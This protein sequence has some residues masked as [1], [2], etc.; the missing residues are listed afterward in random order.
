V[1]YQTAQRDSM[2]IDWD[3]PI[4]MDDGNVLR[5]D[6]FR[7]AQDGQHPLLLTYGPYAKGLHFE[8]GYP[9]A[10][11]MMCAD[12]PDV[13]A[14][15]TNQYQ[16]WEV[17]DPEKWVPEGYVCVRVD[18]RGAG[19]SPGV[20]DCFSPR[21]VQDLY[22]CIEWAG[23]QSWSSGQVALLG[24]SY[25]AVMQ[26]RVAALQPPHLAALVAWEGL[27]DWYRDGGYHGG[28]RS[29]FVSGWYPN[30]VATVQHG[31]GDR[32]KRSRITGL[33][34]A[35]DETLSDEELAANKANFDKAI[36]AHPFDGQFYDERRADLSK[37][38]VPILSAGNWGGHGLHLRGNVEAFLGAASEHKW[39]ELHGVE[40]WVHFYTDYGREL[41]LEFL[42]HF[43][44]GID[45]GWDR[46]PQVLMNVRHPDETFVFR[47]ETAWP[48][49]RT[50]WTE[51]HLDATDMSLR[52]DPPEAAGQV[53]YAPMSGGATFR[54]LI[55]EP[56]E[57]TGPAAATL[58]IA[59]QTED[60]DLFLIL[61]VF[62]PAGVEVAYAGAVQS[63][64]PVAHGWLRASHRQLD[65]E[66]SLRWRPWHPHREREPL[67]PGRTYEVQVEIWPTSIVIPAGYTLALAIQ[68]HDYQP[69]SDVPDI[70]LQWV[71]MR[72][73]GPF[74]HDDPNDRPPEVFG[75]EVTL[76]T[77]GGRSS[78]VLLPVIPQPPI[79]R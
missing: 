55:T 77:G 26:W 68:G 73:V 67:T 33:S 22:E 23:V 14:G 69:P 65:P 70:A 52:P 24:I 10:W 39:L 56:T 25:Y 6:V 8:D 60:A 57:I 43:L 28:I 2:R 30:Q 64:A 17:A 20:I 27:Y 78:H 44:K 35:G 74:K 59:S 16:A 31:L 51:L 37:I 40:H 45:N 61:Q 76:H 58:Q 15:S 29:T 66:R 41:Q 38:T 11:R 63:H 9:D 42:D 53:T 79:T 49:P 62:D 75:G 32:A 71:S 34:V 3:V 12:H 46:R 19:R 13:P 36:E 4:P 5:A 47:E 18:S 48:I 21:E 50:A 54:R 7:P 72:G 1:S